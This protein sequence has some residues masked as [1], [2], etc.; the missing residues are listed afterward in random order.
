MNVSKIK[1]CDSNF[2]D[3]NSYFFV[4]EFFDPKQFLLVVENSNC[5][6]QTYQ[7]AEKHLPPNCCSNCVQSDANVIGFRV[8]MFLGH[9]TSN[10]PG[11]RSFLEILAS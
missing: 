11:N 2:S 4:R 7:I 3:L 9:A 1:S 8:L 6:R 5:L 10:L